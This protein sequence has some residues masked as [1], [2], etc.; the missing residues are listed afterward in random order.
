[1]DRKGRQDPVAWRNKVLVL[2]RTILQLK[3]ENKQLSRQV[4][5]L[6]KKIKSMDRWKQRKETIIAWLKKIFCF[7]K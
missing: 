6:E 7:K 3:A 4:K 1:M 5:R 2:Y